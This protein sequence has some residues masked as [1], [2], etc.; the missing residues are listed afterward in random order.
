MRHSRVHHILI[1]VALIIASYSK[2][3]SALL[4]LNTSKNIKYNLPNFITFMLDILVHL[5]LPLQPQF[6]FTNEL[7]GPFYSSVYD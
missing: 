5:R 1:G 7:F 4:D 2:F 3:N 6:F